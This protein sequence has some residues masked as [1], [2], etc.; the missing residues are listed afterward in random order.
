MGYSQR[1]TV[2]KMQNLA[3]RWKVCISSQKKWKIIKDHPM[4]FTVYLPC[5]S[6]GI[7]QIHTTLLK[8]LGFIQ[9]ICVGNKLT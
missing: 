1:W 4:H 5:A 9:P 8:M 3:E 6:I 7:Y 2:F